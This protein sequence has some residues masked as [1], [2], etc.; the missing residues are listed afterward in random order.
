MHWIEAF[1]LMPLPTQNSP[2]ISFHHTLGRRKLLV[3]SGSMF[4]KISFPQ[5]QKGVEETMICFIKIQSEK[6]KMAWNISLFIFCILIMFFFI[7]NIFW[8]V[9]ALQ[10]CK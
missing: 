6:M 9:M 10:F 5:Q 4:S 3:P 8:N 2:P 1:L 7:F